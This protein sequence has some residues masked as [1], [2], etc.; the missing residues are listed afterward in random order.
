MEITQMQR[1][2][3]L[4]LALAISVRG[5]TTARRLALTKGIKQTIPTIAEG[6]TAPMDRWNAKRVWNNTISG[7][8]PSDILNEASDE[9]GYIREVGHYGLLSA[10]GEVFEN[11]VELGFR[12]LFKDP[13]EKPLPSRFDRE[14]MIHA[15][16]VRDHDWA[17]PLIEAHYGAE[18]LQAAA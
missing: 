14:R 13:P 11:S 5:I 7:G 15:I 1:W 12:M 4:S 17:I 2:A 3:T 16:P 18:R 8:H 9:L 10:T 6:M